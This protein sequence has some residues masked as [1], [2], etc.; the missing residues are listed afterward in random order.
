[1]LS[2]LFIKGFAT[3]LGV[4]SSTIAIAN[5]FVAI[6]DGTIS[7]EERN[8]M[9]VVYVVLRVAMALILIST[10]GI[11]GLRLL[12]NDLEALTSRNLVQ[13][14]LLFVLY[15]NAI[16]MTMRIMPSKFGPAIQAG[17]WYTLGFVVLFLPQVAADF[18]VTTFV[19]SYLAFLL[20]V[21][22]LVNGIMKW[23]KS[24]NQQPKPTN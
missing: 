1:M 20:F 14:I 24:R 5:F 15:T 4:G 3:S 19:L 7:K 6:K 9:Q 11:L 17:T 12:E 2:L 10:L 18:T 8:L 16:L 23:L 22:L 13:V 21:I